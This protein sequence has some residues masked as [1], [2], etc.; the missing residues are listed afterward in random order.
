M[1]SRR[2]G[3]TLVE[4]AA[5]VAAV[6][7]LAAVLTPALADVRHRGKDTVCLQNLARIAQA[8]TI[9]AVEDPG[10]QAVPMHAIMGYGPAWSIPDYIILGRLR[11]C[12]GGKAGR[13][14]EGVMRD[15]STVMGVG[16]AKRP[17]NAVIYKPGLPDYSAAP[18]GS[19]HGADVRKRW[20]ADESLD[21][22]VYRCP[23]DTGYAGYGSAGLQA[24]GLSSYDHFGTSYVPATMWIG[25]GPGT[26]L[27]SNGV[28]LH[29]LA[30]VPSPA[31]T[32]WYYEEC[33][34]FATFVP[35]TPV[36]CADGIDALI[37]G[38]HGKY[39]QFSVAFADGHA[40]SVRIRGHTNPELGHYPVYPD[41]HSTGYDCFS[42][43]IYRGP[44]WQL[45]TLPLTPVLTELI[46]WR[47]ADEVSSDD[48]PTCLRP[49]EP[50][51]DDVG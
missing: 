18:Y 11:H 17:L 24:S 50:E 32:L 19:Y 47:T 40:D 3:I 36:C 7:V 13:G 20:T 25:Y 12:Y 4:L 42:C 5:T 45:D 31:D 34:R 1:I 15:W 46:W 51:L 22:R 43:V 23:A 33:A 48:C 9:Y 41:C 49:V 35:P 27:S 28:M 16:P 10:G 37:L 26:S 14:K 44:G 39:F 30:D 38:W 21:L 6:A 29:R 8:S 2:P